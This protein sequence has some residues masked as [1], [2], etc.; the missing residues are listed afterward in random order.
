MRAKLNCAH[1]ALTL[2]HPM[3]LHVLDLKH[4]RSTILFLF[5]LTFE[6]P[7]S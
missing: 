7:Y 4:I 6:D 1:H 3:Q 5:Q 2:M